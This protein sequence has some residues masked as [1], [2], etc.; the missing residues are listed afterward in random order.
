M[1]NKEES[2]EKKIIE[3]FG[4]RLRVRVCGILEDEDSILLVRHT[5]IGKK[6]VLWAPP[7]GGMKFGSD[8]EHNLIRE[9]KEEAGLDISVEEFLFIHEFLSPPLHAIEM[10]FRV[11]RTGGELTVG[12][13]P[14]M[15]KN[16]QIIKEIRFVSREELLSMDSDIVHN[17]LSQWVHFKSFK[18]R[19]GYFKFE[20]NQ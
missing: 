9:F 10:F 16:D 19:A 17:A 15:E 6:G 12:H 14:E 5:S 3:Y 20:Q 7:G 1:I 8:A 11:R 4:N 13:D 18:S 2:M